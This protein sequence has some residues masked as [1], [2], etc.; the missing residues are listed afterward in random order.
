MSFTLDRYAA[1]KPSTRV[2]GTPK[3]RIGPR[4]GPH[5]READRIADAVVDD[6]SARRDSVRLSTALTLQR[7]SSDAGEVE[8]PLTAGEVLRSPGQPLEPDVRSFMNARFGHDFSKIRV[9]TGEP[10][11]LYAQ[12]VSARAF[13]VGNDI[14]FGHGQ[15]QPGTRAGKRLIAHELA[16]SLQQGAGGGLG[17]AWLQRK[18]VC[19]AASTT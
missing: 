14:V 10:A 5:E 15:Y 1:A 8:A 4:L 6:R 7:D 19:A 9:H 16:H 17:T 13:T 11:A 3:L 18:T 12:V 2:Q